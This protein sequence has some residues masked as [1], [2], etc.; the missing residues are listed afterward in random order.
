[1]LNIMKPL[2]RWIDVSGRK[3]IRLLDKDYLAKK[4]ERRQGRCKRCG[5]C[6]KKCRLLDKKTRLCTT[7]ENRPWLCYKEFPLDEFD[8]KLWDTKDCGYCFDKK[9]IH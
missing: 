3:L 4:L 6:C 5:E 9:I 7:Y 8:K 2:L 1:M